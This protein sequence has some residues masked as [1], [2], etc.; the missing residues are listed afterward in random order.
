VEAI[1]EIKAQS[2]QDRDQ[3]QYEVFIHEFKVSRF[4]VFKVRTVP[5]LSKFRV[6]VSSKP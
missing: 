1:E 5:R 4:R 6:S 2:D 3:D